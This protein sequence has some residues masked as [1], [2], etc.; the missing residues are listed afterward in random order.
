[1]GNP[2]ATALY[3]TLYRTHI[4]KTQ[5]SSYFNLFLNDKKFCYDELSV[6][7]DAV[8]E[9][10]IRDVQGAKEGLLKLSSNVDPF[11]WFE[12]E[13]RLD[14]LHWAVTQSS[15]RLYTLYAKLAT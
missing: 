7:V 5:T 11:Q 14:E 3:L 13:M 10:M 15:K 8:L 12:A 6:I 1:M 9:A 4:S 2:L